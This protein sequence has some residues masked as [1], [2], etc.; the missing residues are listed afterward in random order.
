[1]RLSE[2][3]YEN[4]AAWRA[5]IVESPPRYTKPSWATHDRYPFLEPTV[6]F[7]NQFPLEAPT[8]DFKNFLK[9]YV[10][11]AWLQVGGPVPCTSAALGLVICGPIIRSNCSI[12]A[13]FVSHLC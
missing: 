7:V 6:D 8:D 12:G 10:T 2:L 5:A 3:W 13:E 4:A 11:I 9:P 1:V